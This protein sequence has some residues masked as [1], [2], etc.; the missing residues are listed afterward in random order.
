VSKPTASPI[1][2]RSFSAPATG[3]SDGQARG[4]DTILDAPKVLGGE[5][6]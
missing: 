3:S 2:R 6:S 1:E 5:V 4:F